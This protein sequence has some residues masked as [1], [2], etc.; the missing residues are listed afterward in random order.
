MAFLQEM[1]QMIIVFNLN[2][3]T[4][5][6]N[7]EPSQS[8]LSTGISKEV[9]KHFYEYTKDICVTYETKVWTLNYGF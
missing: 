1:K 6:S 5:D 2:K 7:K 3:K 8:F 4:T 9:K